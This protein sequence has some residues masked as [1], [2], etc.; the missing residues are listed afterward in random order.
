MGCV[1]DSWVF[2]LTF[3]AALGCGVVGGVF[4]AFSTFVMNGLARLPVPHGIAAMRSIN[5]TAVRPLFMSALFGTAAVCLALGATG[6]A[7]WGEDRAALLMVGSGLY[8]AGNVVVTVV[9]NVPLNDSLATADPDGEDAPGR[10]K[11]YIRVWSRWNHVRTITAVSASAM[12]VV[13]LA[14]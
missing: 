11:S 14:G 8:L 12:F 2:P 7:N 9:G 5:E 10:W 13:A 4:F 1:L 6:V 3:A